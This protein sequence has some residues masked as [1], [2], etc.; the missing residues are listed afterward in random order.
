MQSRGGGDVEG[1]LGRAHLLSAGP[2]RGQFVTDSARMATN[3][4]PVPPFPQID[5]RLDKRK[6]GVYGPPIGKRAVVFVDDLNMPAKEVC[7]ARPALQRCMQGTARFLPREFPTLS[8][9]SQPQPVPPCALRSRRRTAPSLPS[10]SCGRPLTRVAGMAG[11]P[12]VGWLVG[13]AQAESRPCMASGGRRRAAPGISSMCCM[14]SASPFRLEP[15]LPSTHAPRA[16][17]ITSGGRWPTSN[18]PRPWAR[19]AAPG[20]SSRRAP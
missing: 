11:A 9:V 17:G 7:G 6:K 20:R 18:G 4:H 19:P 1:L 14:S 2:R 12:R 16:P 5:G 10:S 8:F 13:Q 15:H 3:A